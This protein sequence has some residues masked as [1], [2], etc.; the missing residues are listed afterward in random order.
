ML[1]RALTISGSAIHSPHTPPLTDD[2]ASLARNSPPSTDRQRVILMPARRSPRRRAN[3]TPVIDGIF[4]APSASAPMQRQQS[5]QVIAGQGIVGDRYAK[6]A[7]TYD[8]L[9]A[10]V[11]KP[12]ER[13]PGRSITLVSASDVEKALDAAGVQPLESIGDLRRNIAIHGISAKELMDSIGV[14]PARSRWPAAAPTAVLDLTATPRSHRPRCRSP[15]PLPGR[16]ARRW[17]SAPRWSSSC[18]VTAPRACTTRSAT[19]VLA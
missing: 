10:S 16:Q 1:F 7:G 2:G 4:I 18:T 15:V 3:T 19:A 9:R 11:K 5:V 8:V 14:A 17:L 12:G 6:D 13:E